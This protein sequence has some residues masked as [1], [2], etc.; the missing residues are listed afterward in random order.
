VIKRF[1]SGGYLEDRYG[2]SRVVQAGPLV[3]VAGCTSNID[4][5][6]QHAGAPYEQATFAFQMAL[7]A[8]TK[9]GARVSDVVRTRMY[10]VGA[11]HADA[12]GRAHGATFGEVRPVATMV[13]VERLVDPTM[14]VE[15]EVEAY[16]P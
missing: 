2:Y 16:K 4:G 9:A 10:V 13:M 3:L 7:D 12:V 11:E 6:V 15:V 14:L 1:G 8:L 5:V